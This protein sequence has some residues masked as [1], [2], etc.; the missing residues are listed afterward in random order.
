MAGVAA[1]T[2]AA[3]LAGTA[4]GTTCG[5]GEPTARGMVTLGAF[6][7]ENDDA[8]AAGYWVGESVVMLLFGQNQLAQ[9][10]TTQSVQQSAVP[11]ADFLNI[12]EQLLGAPLSR[13]AGGLD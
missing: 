4:K 2:D 12:T 3:W 11:D 13:S 5:L 8:C 1:G 6:R 10:G 7:L 9:L